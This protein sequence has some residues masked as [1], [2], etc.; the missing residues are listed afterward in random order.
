MTAKQRW[1]SLVDLKILHSPT[2]AVDKGRSALTPGITA[3]EPYATTQCVVLPSAMRIM[4]GAGLNTSASTSRATW[5]TG[6]SP[7]ATILRMST[8]ALTV[9]ELQRKDW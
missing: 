1:T 5:P 4:H 7:L 8:R 3:L 9:T 2:T 6:Q